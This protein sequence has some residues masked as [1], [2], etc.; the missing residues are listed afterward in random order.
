MYPGLL[1]QIQTGAVHRY[2]GSLLYKKIYF[3][4]KTMVRLLK[5]KILLILSGLSL[6][7]LVAGL[8]LVYA[9][10]KGLSSP[11]IIHINAFQGV[12]MMGGI[13]NL[14]N[15]LLMG[16]L[17]FVINNALASV[18]FLRE[19]ILSYIV[20]TINFIISLFILINVANIIMLN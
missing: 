13:D 16:T 10:I 3:I 17:I 11:L 7:M 1:I 4:I 19:R 5:D 12:D 6:L 20:L 14:W 9:N 18:F 8:I 2:A 15:I